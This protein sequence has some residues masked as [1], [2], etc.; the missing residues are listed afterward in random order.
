[1]SNRAVV[2]YWWI[3]LV[4][5][6]LV[7]SDR[8][9]RHVSASGIPALDP[10]Y[11]SGTLQESGLPV[12]GMRALTLILWDSDTAT[13]S[14]DNKCQTTASTTQVTNGRFRLP[15]DISCTAAVSAT[16]DLW[17]EVIVGTLSLGR[18]KLGAVPYAVEASRASAATGVLASQIV[19]SGAVTYFNGTTCPAG[20]T[21]LVAAR[22]RYVV[23]LPLGGTLAGIDGTPLTDLLDRP[24]GQHTHT[25]MMGGMHNHNGF[26]GGTVSGDTNL[27]NNVAF[28][29]VG[30]GEAPSCSAHVGETANTGCYAYYKDHTHS[31]ASDPGH[32][33]TINASGTPG[34]NAPYIQLLVCQKS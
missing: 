16:P 33:H 23:G 29:A 28:G 4:V 7:T 27:D 31:I 5:A 12:T 3:P 15:L 13:A 30:N 10:L 17:I 21:E 2:R 19:P 6:G 25:M 1:M 18:K 32:V 20:W 9:T 8:W 22:G 11:Y 34:T 26:T 24:T 14:S